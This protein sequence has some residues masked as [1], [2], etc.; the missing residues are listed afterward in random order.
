MIATVRAVVVV[1]AALTVIY[2]I[3]SLYSRARRRA[4]LERQ[5]NMDIRTGDREAFVRE[6][7]KK[8]DASLRKKLILG[9]YIL[10]VA[11]VGLVI[12]ITNFM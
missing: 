8:Y 11:T 9:V 5:W 2:V 10:P 7:M 12:Y 6:G 4:R 1:F 3:V